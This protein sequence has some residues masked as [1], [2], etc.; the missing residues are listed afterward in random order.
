MQGE[1]SSART[2]VK[3][4]PNLFSTV[5]LEGRVC[6]EGGNVPPAPPCAAPG[7]SRGTISFPCQGRATQSTPLLSHKQGGHSSR[8][9]ELWFPPVFLPVF[10]N[11]RLTANWYFPSLSG[12]FSL[13]SY[14]H[15]SHPEKGR[16]DLR[17]LCRKRRRQTN[18][19]QLPIATGQIAS[20]K[21]EQPECHPWDG[22]ETIFKSHKTRT[23]HP[24]SWDC[25]LSGFL[26]R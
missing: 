19:L 1:S 9:P 13:T 25:N 7:I 17:E 3:A 18:H 24:G 20:S 14:S 2:D 11:K 4:L 8:G 10:I 21:K 6:T 15:N 16:K 12:W 23:N 26:P 22:L 5:D